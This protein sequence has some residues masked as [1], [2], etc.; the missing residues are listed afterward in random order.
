[1]GENTKIQWATHTLNFWEGCTKVSEGCAHCYAADRDSRFHAGAHWGP[2][3]PRRLTS[4]SNWAQAGKWNREALATG[5]RPRIFVNSLSDIFDPEVPTEWRRKA[6]DVI[7]ENQA[8]DFLLVTKRPELA[9]DLIHEAGYFDRWCP[10]VTPKNI[11]MGV[12]C[13]NQQ[14]A[15]ERMMPLDD[16]P[17]AVKFVSAEPMLSPI[18]FYEACYGGKLRFGEQHEK[19]VLFFDWLICGGES[20][21]DARAF[22]VA[23]ARSLRAQCKAGGVAFF[24]KQLGAD[25]YFMR[26]DMPGG[27][28]SNVRFPLELADKKGGDMEEWPADLRVRELPEVA[29]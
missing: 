16:I 25:P 1:M 15:N 9:F 20:G 28:L 12:T 3:A 17:A 24:M 6:L 14:R 10:T 18:D 19:D 26:T 21:R 11:W 5:V 7:W 22:N 23:W 13:E 2:G 4:V 8:C 29:R 27:S